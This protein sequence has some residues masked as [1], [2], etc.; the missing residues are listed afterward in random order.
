[1]GEIA[2]RLPHRLLPCAAFAPPAY[3]SSTGEHPCYQ[4]LVPLSCCR[5][6]CFCLSSVLPLLPSMADRCM[7]QGLPLEHISG[8]DTHLVAR[9]GSFNH[10]SLPG[11]REQHVL[12]P[13]SARRPLGRARQSSRRL[14]V[15]RVTVPVRLLPIWRSGL[16]V[17]SAVWRTSTCWARELPACRS[18]VTAEMIIGHSG[19]KRSS[20]LVLAGCLG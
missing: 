10:N 3:Q 2:R 8:V 1:M 17:E 4:S 6:R 7:L 5:R 19:V 13:F 14:L 9:L 20:Y 18:D 12:R 15:R 16:C 11:R